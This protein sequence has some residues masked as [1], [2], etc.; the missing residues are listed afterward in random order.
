MNYL[1]SYVGIRT[2]LILVVFCCIGAA[3]ISYLLPA[4]R[5][6]QPTY[7][8]QFLD[9]DPETYLHLEDLNFTEFGFRIYAYEQN[10]FVNAIHGT[11]KWPQLA[12]EHGHVPALKFDG[13]TFIIF[14]K[15]VNE[16]GGLAIS[17][18]KQFATKLEKY[19]D[20]FCLLYTSPS[21]RD[22][23]GARMPSSA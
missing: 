11:D 15:W 17:D 20:D 5:P 2:I 4:L 19:D 13:D 7:Y 23:R 22:Q 14:R 12:D 16:S 9:V 8:A 10:Q 1:E 3:G 21:P 6:L 18:D